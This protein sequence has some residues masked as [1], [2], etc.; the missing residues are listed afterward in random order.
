MEY[1]S[2]QF[3]VRDLNKTFDFYSNVLGFEIEKVS[4]EDEFDF[5]I[6]QQSDHEIMFE[7]ESVVKKLHPKISDGWKGKKG[8]GV[9]LNFIVD[10]IYEIYGRVKAHNVKV[11]YDIAD[12][13][14]GMREVWI[15]D[16]DDYL[17]VI[18]EAIEE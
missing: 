3:T 7:Q 17:I 15:Y 14:Y 11:L 5:L 9:V 8:S 6:M 4:T 12:K 2:F 18:S 10:N 13:H 1:S 16:P